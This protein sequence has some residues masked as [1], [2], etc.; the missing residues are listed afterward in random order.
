MRCIH[1]LGAYAC[2]FFRHST[3]RDI[4]SNTFLPYTIVLVQVVFIHADTNGH[5]MP[6]RI[7]KSIGNITNYLYRNICLGLPDSSAMDVYAFTTMQQ[8]LLVWYYFQYAC[9]YTDWNRYSA[10]KRSILNALNEQIHNCE[11]TTPHKKKNR[12]QCFFI[13]YFIFH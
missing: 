7:F 5:K 1:V 6:I 2:C 12:L 4:M 3:N 13:I 10:T 11:P 9:L 8:S